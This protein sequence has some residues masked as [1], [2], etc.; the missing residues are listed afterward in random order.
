M[1]RPR[2]R[3]SQW[4]PTHAPMRVRIVCQIRGSMLGR[5]DSGSGGS[6]RRSKILS[7]IVA[8]IPA[9]LLV[10]SHLSLG[11]AKADECRIKP[12]SAAPAGMHWYYR[13]D[14]TNNRHCWYLHAQGMPVHS[15]VNATARNQDIQNDTVDEQVAKTPDE[16]VAQTPLVIETPQPAYES[17][18]SA[19]DRPPDFTGRW[20][21]LPKS[22]DLNAHELVAASNGYAPE[23]GA[24]NTQQQLAPAW[25]GV[26]AVNGEVRQNS[27]AGTSFGS[28]SL[29]GAAVL[30]LL[31]IS[32]ALLRLVRTSGWCLLRRQLR[33]GSYPPKADCELAIESFWQIS[34][35]RMT[36]PFEP[37][38]AQTGAG[39]LRSLL[40]RASSGLKPPQSFAPSGSVHQHDH[41]GRAHAQSALQ[42][43]KSRSFSGMTWA[44]L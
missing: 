43:L 13:V 18:D 20:V 36:P 31:L 3:I 40:Q 42:R 41:G 28:I 5:D 44:P 38:G 25:P 23:Q 16:L 17:S 14:R 33:A 6:M 35:S 19:A 37:S 26:A 9:F 21:D 12:D 1:A 29:V 34:D 32:E 30:A 11:A 39:E 7:G 27:P 24:A 15:P 22:V 4:Q 8:L 2:W 10:M